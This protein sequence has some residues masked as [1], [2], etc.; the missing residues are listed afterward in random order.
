MQKLEFLNLEQENVS[1]FFQIVFGSNFEKTIVIF[2]IS[3][4][5]FALLQSLVKI[6]FLKF[7]TKFALF[8]YFWAGI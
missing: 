2:E 3:T 4:L 5:E 8:K 1:V 6:K 7:G